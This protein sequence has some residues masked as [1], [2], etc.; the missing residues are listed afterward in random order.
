[1]ATIARTAALPSDVTEVAS[2]ARVRSAAML[3]LIALAAL[4][5]FCWRNYMVSDDTPYLA[6]SDAFLHGHW[7]KTVFGLWSP[8]YPAF[9]AAVRFAFRVGPLGEPYAV[10]A[11]TFL[12]FLLALAGFEFLLRQMNRREGSWLMVAYGT[13]GVA[14]IGL[15]LPAQAPDV[16][17]AAFIFVAAGLMLRFRS[18]HATVRESFLLGLVLGL[19][20]LAKAPM[21]I[22][23]IIFLIEFGILVRNFSRLAVAILAFA[24]ISAPLIIGLSQRLGYITFRE[25]AKIN[26][27]FH[28]NARQCVT[29]LNTSPPILFNPSATDWYLNADLACRTIAPVVT[30]KHQ[31]AYSARI[32]AQFAYE[33]FFQ[34]PGGMLLVALLCIYRQP[35]R[36]RSA[37]PLVVPSLAGIAMYCLVHI[38]PRYIF[39]L[40]VLIALMLFKDAHISAARGRAFVLACC[41]IFCGIFLRDLHVATLP[42]TQAQVASRLQ[43]LG[44]SKNDAVATVVGN[45]DAAWIRLSRVRVVASVPFDAAAGQF[46]A[47]DQQAS[48]AVMRQA[49]ARAVV[50]SQVPDFGDLKSWIDLGHGY[51]LKWL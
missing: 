16:L 40:L 43:S 22:L 7:T 10:N 37:W 46:W 6:I 33:F 20:Y 1:M 18:G 11:A 27:I 5:A 34:G 14:T 19:G 26:Y 3:S 30:I 13:F 21:F 28:V 39:A 49:G 29:P 45:G 32:S 48:F 25:S 23:A 8:L 2:P 9:I 12:T 41:A 47:Q 4:R 35:L 42:D 31:L 50:V 44:V 17:Q 51:Y 38:E 15:A 24:L 36:W